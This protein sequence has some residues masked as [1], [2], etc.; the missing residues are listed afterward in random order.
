MMRIAR[1]NCAV[2]VQKTGE[3]TVRK[4]YLLMIENNDA[5]IFYGNTILVSPFPIF[6]IRIGIFD[7]EIP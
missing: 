1:N 3:Q 4:R 6:L 7:F 5:D 2:I